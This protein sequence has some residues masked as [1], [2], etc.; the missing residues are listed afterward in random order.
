VIVQRWE[1]GP[2]RTIASLALVQRA[3]VAPTRDE[4]QVTIQGSSLNFHD[5]LVASG[6]IKASPGRVP[7]SDGVGVVEACGPDVRDFAPGDRVMGT[8]FADWLDGPPL[9]DRIASMRGDHTDG[10]AA[11]RVTMPASSFTRAPESLSSLAAATLPCAGLTAWRALMVE[12][13]IKP[14]DSVLVQ[15]SGGVSL[16]ALQFARLAGARVIATTS[17]TE[18]AERLK[19]LGASDVVIYGQDA[20]WGRTVCELSSGG[21]DFLVEVAGGD[22]SQ[23]LHALR[24]G[25][26]LCLVGALSRQPIQFPTVQMIHANRWITGVTVG[27]RQHQIDMVRAVDAHGLQPVVDSIYPFEALDDAFTRF[28][29]QQQFGKI[30]IDYA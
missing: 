23:S 1:V 14:G 17:S 5:Y 12:G 9:A 28:A 13:R 2:E 6:T 16:F 7:L 3:D 29:G 4:I 22:L 18:K 15:G 19:A 21:V 26:K 27:S 10:F 24:V 25:G 8:F 11:T 30:A 20:Q